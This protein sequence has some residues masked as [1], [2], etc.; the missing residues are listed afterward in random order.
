MLPYW[1]LFAVFALGAVNYRLRPRTESE[2][3]SPFLIAALLATMLMIGLRDEVG[4][5]WYNYL[6]IYDMAAG[7][8]LSE[9]LTNNDPGYF[10]LNWI[11]YRLGFE[12]WL[13]NLVCAAGFIWGLSRF[14]NA[15]PNPWLAMA[16]AVPNLV[17]VVAMGYTRQA[18]AI[19]LVMAAFG[20]FQR[21]QYVRFALLFLLAASIHKSAI[22]VLP[23]IA[24]STVRH[25]F[26]VYATAASMGLVIFFLFLDA[27]LNTVFSTYIETEMSADGALVRL[28]MN[29]L[30]AMIFFLR[31]RHFATS[32]QELVIWRN[33]SL[34]SLAMVAAFVLLPSSTLVDRV[35]LYMTPIQLFV[36]SR[37]PYTFPAK[38]GANGLLL[39]A[40][41]AYSAAIQLVWLVFAKHA[42]AWLPYKHI[43]ILP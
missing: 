3:A 23:L 29:I 8:S 13:V 17:I 36:L 21:S 24:L 14:V 26:M 39:I 31:P 37:L 25:R 6:I 28:A 15:Q 4:A 16:V 34:A 30:P 33:F 43:A 38:G 18:V 1:L 9:V 20:P 7:R 35:A 27:F 10:L 40:V 42:E 22:V 12:I 2:R 5:D 32:D 19:G 41:L 11:A